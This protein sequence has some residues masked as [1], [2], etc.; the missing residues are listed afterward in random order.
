MPTSV[1]RQ[2][3]EAFDKLAKDPNRR[4]LDIKPLQERDGFRLR[5]QGRRAIYSIEH[6]RLIILVLDIGA[7]GDIYK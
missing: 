2:F 1:A 3:R 7:R 6:T 4:D 5:V